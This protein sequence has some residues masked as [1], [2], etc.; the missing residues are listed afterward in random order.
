[1]KGRGGWCVDSGDEHVPAGA[2][3]LVAGLEWTTASRGSFGGTEAMARELE[4]RLPASLLSGFQIFT[5]A[6]TELAAGKVRVFWCHC[7]P[8]QSP[9]ACLA[10]GGWRNFH[11]IVFV[12]NWQAQAFIRQFGIPWSRCQVILNA[13]EPIGISA[14]RFAPIPPGTTIR[15]VYTPAPNRGLAILYAIFTRICEVRDDVELD[16]FSSWKLYGWDSDGPF[17][18]LLAALRRHP[19]VRYHGAVPN[20]QVRAALADCH[21]FAYPAVFE[22][23]SCLCLIEAMSAGL[24][25]VHPNYGALYETAAGWTMMYQWQ[26]DP[27]AHTAAFCHALMTAIDALRDASAGLLP[28]LAAQKNYADYHYGWD[29]R[30]MQWQAF[31]QSISGLPAD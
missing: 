8:D 11:R 22:E 26:E 16:V 9:A 19:R 6:P 17:E 3:R 29:R 18:D 13:I 5:S 27:H 10:N 4:R 30:V 31:L 15:L 1:M 14:G 23:T 7:T 12:S 25:C 24:A 2:R 20:Q 21:V 28:L